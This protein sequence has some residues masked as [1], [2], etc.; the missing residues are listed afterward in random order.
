MYALRQAIRQKWGRS[1]QV[2]SLLLEGLKADCDNLHIRPK[3]DTYVCY[4]P[5][6]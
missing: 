3:S 5:L 1:F 4:D 2:K 6:D